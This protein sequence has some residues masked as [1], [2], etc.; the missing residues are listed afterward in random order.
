M[1]LRIFGDRPLALG[2]EKSG[3]FLGAQRWHDRWAELLGIQSTGGGE[4]GVADRF[5]VQAL[6]RE[7]G[8]QPVLGI[9]F[10]GLGGGDALHAIGAGEHDELVQTLEA[11]AV[12]HEIAR[13]PVE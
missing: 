11:P 7:M 6:A 13:E 3:Q 1:L 4:D 5:A 10:R 8:E 9:D 2:V 12:I